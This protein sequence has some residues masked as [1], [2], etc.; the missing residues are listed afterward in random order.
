MCLGTV[1]RVLEVGADALAVVE[2]GSVENCAVENGVLENGAVEPA[3]VPHPARRETV[4]DMTDEDLQPGDWVVIH[5]GFALER[6]SKE[7]AIDALAIRATPP[8][9]TSSDGTGPHSTPAASPAPQ[10][11][12]MAP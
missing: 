3:S 11:K 10:Q 7:Q 2:H 9:A 8:P 4:L 5:S 1:A 6:I 12:E